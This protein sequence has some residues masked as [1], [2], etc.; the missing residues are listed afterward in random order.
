MLNGFTDDISDDI[1]N[2]IIDD[3]TDHITDDIIQRIWQLAVIFSYW[4]VFRNIYVDP[5]F[6]NIH[7]TNVH[8]ILQ[9]AEQAQYE[10]YL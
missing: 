7:S 1:S 5:I 10:A 8:T 6:H 9:Q 2:D 3:I 4:K